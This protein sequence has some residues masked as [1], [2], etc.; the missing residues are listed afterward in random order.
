MKKCV[1][2]LLVALSLTL[3]ACGTKTE[4]EGTTPSSTTVTA[5]REGMNALEDFVLGMT[6]EQ[7]T[8]KG[9]KAFYASP[10]VMLTT[11]DWSG[12]AWNTQLLF[13]NDKLSILILSTPVS[14]EVL[15]LALNFA[16]A[17]G[18]MP[19]SVEQGGVE[20]SI[21]ALAAQGKT[22]A[23]CDLV[24]GE[25]ITDFVKNKNQTCTIMLSGM[26][27]FSKLVAAMQTNG[28][29]EEIFGDAKDEPLLAIV[30]DKQ[31]NM[32]NMIFSSWGIMTSD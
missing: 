5:P 1:I 28:N 2:G 17:R 16:G 10:G 18:Y 15:N 30:I 24:L 22:P 31:D 9:A 21:Y 8:A 26:N 6:R 12:Y 14:S 7:A 25:Q 29:E 11:V 3:A 32:I 19:F 4:G 13:E 23:E 20:T 27:L